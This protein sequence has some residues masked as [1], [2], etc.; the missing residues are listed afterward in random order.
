M[1]ASC[2]A[3]RGMLPSESISRN[4]N[5][6]AKVSCQDLVTL[7]EV[8][9]IAPLS[10]FIALTEAKLRNKC[11]IQGNQYI[12]REFRS[13]NQYCQSSCLKGAKQEKEC[14]RRCVWMT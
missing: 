4:A 8:A 2:A 10:G 3:A 1:S 9:I 13:T 14:N 7:R 6:E 5:S 11:C 12:A